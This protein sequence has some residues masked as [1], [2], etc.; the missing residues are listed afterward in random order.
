MMRDE[1]QFTL[2][3]MSTSLLELRP[4]SHRTPLGEAGDYPRSEWLLDL[5]QGSRLS[6]SETAPKDTLACL[7]I[8]GCY[9]C[10]RSHHGSIIAQHPH[11]PR[12]AL[13]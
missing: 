12:A 11:G 6:K 4:D 5:K 9:N 3:L 2:F 1:G 7:P 13:L 10:Y 8:L